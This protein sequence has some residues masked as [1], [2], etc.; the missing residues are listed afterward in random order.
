MNIGHHRICLMIA[1]E[2]ASFCC[3]LLYIFG[4][5]TRGKS[6]DSTGSNAGVLGIYTD[7][8]RQQHPRSNKHQGD[9]E[10][11]VSGGVEGKTRYETTTPRSIQLQGCSAETRKYSA[12]ESE[13]LVKRALNSTDSSLKPSIYPKGTCATLH[14]SM[15]ISRN[16]FGNFYSHALFIPSYNS[17]RLICNC[18]STVCKTE[19]KENR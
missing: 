13:I 6:A 11:G 5:H 4:R 7:P 18:S 12:L 19:R 2:P 9:S 8:S 14:H 10:L 1:V 17:I 16:L 15:D 3:G